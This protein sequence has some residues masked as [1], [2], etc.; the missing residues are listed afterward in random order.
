MPHKH[1]GVLFNCPSGAMRLAKQAFNS[2]QSDFS[3]LS[4]ASF[5]TILHQLCVQWLKCNAV[6][7]SKTWP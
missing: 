3:F 2:L 4:L 5:N 1:C 6:L 7:L